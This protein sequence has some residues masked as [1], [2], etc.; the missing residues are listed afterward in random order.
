MENGGSERLREILG[1][2]PGRDTVHAKLVGEG[3]VMRLPDDLKV[4][5]A[6]PGLHAELKEFLGD[7]CVWEQ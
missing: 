1:R 5:K 4:D 7:Q 6:I 3:R 2:Y